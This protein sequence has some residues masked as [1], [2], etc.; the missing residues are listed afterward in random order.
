[1]ALKNPKRDNVDPTTGSG[2]ED[3]ENHLPSEV[4]RRYD[5]L[6]AGKTK[7]ISLEELFT[8]L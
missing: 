1:M 6:K 2:E 5:A 7:P 4:R 3:Q 8:D